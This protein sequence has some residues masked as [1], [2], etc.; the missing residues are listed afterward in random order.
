MVGNKNCETGVVSASMI[1]IP[2]SWKSVN[3]FK[4][5]QWGT[6]IYTQ[7]R[8]L[9][10]YD[11]ITF[12]VPEKF[13]LHHNITSRHLSS[14]VY[15]VTFKCYLSL[16]DDGGSKFLW[17]AGQY[18]PEYTAQHHIRRHENLKS[19]IRLTNWSF[20]MHISALVL[21]FMY[22]FYQPMRFN[23]SRPQVPYLA[24]SFN[25]KILE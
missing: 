24:V 2:M 8:I 16:P 4:Y 17:N 25:V 5:C 23:I 11:T 3:M 21:S 9:G 15:K 10:H 18:L 12:S 6:D 7:T 14:S 19:H 1:F 22:G 20:S 13:S